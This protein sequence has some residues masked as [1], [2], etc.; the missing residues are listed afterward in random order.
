M[1]AALAPVDKFSKSKKSAS[2]SPLARSLEANLSNHLS[3]LLLLVRNLVPSLANF[4]APEN[5][6]LN[7]AVN[8]PP[9][10]PNFNL[11]NNSV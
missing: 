9:S 7:P 11:F 2:L 8:K 10:V 3:N 5:I 1:S 4:L 6:P